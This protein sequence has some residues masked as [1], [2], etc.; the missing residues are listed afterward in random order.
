MITRKEEADAEA[1][2]QKLRLRKRWNQRKSQFWKTATTCIY[3]YVY[4]HIDDLWLVS[5]DW[6]IKCLQHGLCDIYIYTYVYLY[7]R[8]IQNKA[9]SVTGTGTVGELDGNSFYYCNISTRLW[10]LNNPHIDEIMIDENPKYYD[11]GSETKNPSQ[12]WFIMVY[13]IGCDKPWIGWIPQLGWRWSP[14]VPIITKASLLR[15]RRNL[16]LVTGATSLMRSQATNMGGMKGKHFIMT[17][18][19]IYNIIYL[20]ISITYSIYLYLYI[21]IIYVSISTSIY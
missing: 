6:I 5:V 18:T 12:S 16:P 4:I 2:R 20:L 11:V 7:L 14:L 13:D 8:W 15:R 3:I 19:Y 9:T 21:Y 17:H 1:K 10:S